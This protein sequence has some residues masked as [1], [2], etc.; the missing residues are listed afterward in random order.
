MALIRLELLTDTTR[1]RAMPCMETTNLS[2]PGM[3]KRMTFCGVPTDLH[4]L[5]LY[6]NFVKTWLFSCGTLSAGKK[7]G[8]E[9]ILPTLDI[10]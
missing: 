8:G 10:L 2:P 3:I 7:F 6:T 9:C 4:E 1:N 5:R